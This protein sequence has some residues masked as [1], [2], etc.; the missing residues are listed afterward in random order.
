MRFRRID[1]YEV[2]DWCLSSPAATAAY[3]AGTKAYRRPAS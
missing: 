2:R 1:A 3:C